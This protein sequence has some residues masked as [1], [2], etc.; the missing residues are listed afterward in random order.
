MHA[1]TPATARGLPDRPGAALRLGVITNPH[2]GRNRRQ[3]SAVRRLLETSGR[4]RHI[5]TEDSAAIPRALDMR[6]CTVFGD[7]L[8]ADVLI[9]VPIVK[10][11][12]LAVM[13]A[14]MKNLMM[15]GCQVPACV[16]NGVLFCAKE[17]PDLEALEAR[18]QE[19]FQRTGMK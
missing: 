1:T 9:D 7:V 5:V 15:K 3:L 18:V 16:V 13:S 11:H 14:G 19:V 6:S 12:S 10:Q 4:V 17:V 2:S 8:Q